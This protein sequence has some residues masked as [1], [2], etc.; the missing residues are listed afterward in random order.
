MDEIT[1]KKHL[2]DLKNEEST[3]KDYDQQELLDAMLEHIGSPDPELRDEL[4]YHQFSQIIHNGDQLS[5]ETLIDLLTKALGDEYLFYEIGEV[6][7][8]HVFKRS[9]SVL[10]ITLILS[11][12]LEHSFI[13]LPLLDKARTE[14]LLYLDLEH[15]LRGYVSEKGWAHSVAHTADAIDE[16]VKNPKLKVQ[17][18]P[19]IFQGLVNKVFTFDDVYIADEDER[20]LAPIMTMLE[21][22]LTL[23]TVEGLFDKIPTFLKQQKDKIGEEKYLKL[24]ANCKSFLKSFYIRTRSN[25]KWASIHQRIGK[26]LN[27][28]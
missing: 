11:K 25:D 12:D 14:L 18:F 13:S 7:T 27:E 22:G 15:D 16:I 10:L 28:L 9:F 17:Y 26:C 20:I 6:G 23:E 21:I 2:L 4:I 24:Y 1:L 8:D 5:D 19:S 3:W